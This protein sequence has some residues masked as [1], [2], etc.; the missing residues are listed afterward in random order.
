MESISK[1]FYISIRLLKFS[2]VIL[3]TVLIINFLSRDFPNP[4]FI[5]LI[6]TLI[7]KAL[8]SYS[9]LLNYPNRMVSFFTLGESLEDQI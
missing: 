4:L 2:K 3:V 8:H 9:L 7:L 5:F 1:I 6:G